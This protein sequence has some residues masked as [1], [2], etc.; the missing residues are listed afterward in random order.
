MVSKRNSGL[1]SG[2]GGE[3]P[4]PVGGRS[5]DP[6][7]SPWRSRLAWRASLAE[8]RGERDA[9]RRALRAARSERDAA[10]SALDT[11]LSERD[12]AHEALARARA[13]RDAS[14]RALADALAERK[15]MSETL[16]RMRTIADGAQDERHA[17]VTRRLDE[18]LTES[19]QIH[20]LEKATDRRVRF[21]HRELIT[22]IQALHQLMSRYSPQARLPA[23]AGWALSPSGVLAL[24]DA[25]ERI[26]A[27]IVVECGSG[28]STLW[29]AYALKRL[30]H[31][32]VI[33][34][35]HLPDYAA[36]TRALVAEHG[37][38][39][40]VEVRDA[41]LV[42][43]ETSRGEF[44]WYAIAPGEFE[45]RINVLLVDGPPGATG[46]HAR[47]PALSAFIDR[48]APGAIIMAD[49]VDRRDEREMLDYWL[50]EEPRLRRLDSPG[51][52]IV[53]LLFGE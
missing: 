20:A 43:R 1:G 23:I 30:G 6:P 12:A 3:A 37:L 5:I 8:A 17:Q 2:G 45:E 34:L 7:R 46:R 38:D 48:L 13:E 50:Q 27:Q 18:L 29:I 32:K 9:A 44:S 22:D 26:D 31:G 24:T 40:L 36:K 53:T 14:T 15:S 51:P 11:A 21:L 35:E 10:L 52:G 16:E 39:E 42:P 28:T 49:D 25:I 4:G 41:P 33:A 19:H 47:Y